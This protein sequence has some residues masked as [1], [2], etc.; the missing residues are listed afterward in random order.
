MKQQQ[1]QDLFCPKFTSLLIKTAT[2][3]SHYPAQDFQPA[4]TRVCKGVAQVFE[5]T[6]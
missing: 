2:L 6:L 3:P 5:I 4:E 1:N